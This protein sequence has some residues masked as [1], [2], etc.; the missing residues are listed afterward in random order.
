MPAARRRI[1]GKHD[2]S[3]TSRTSLLPKTMI[4][5]SRGDVLEESCFCLLWKSPSRPIREYK[6]RVSPRNR[7]LPH[8]PLIPP[9]ET[10]AHTATKTLLNAGRSSGSIRIPHEELAKIIKEY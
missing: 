4:E 8:L 10:Q 7:Y 6:I 9:S 3:A 5:T 1:R 2:T